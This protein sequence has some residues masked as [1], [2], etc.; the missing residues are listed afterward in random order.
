MKL[1]L[2]WQKVPKLCILVLLGLTALFWYALTCSHFNLKNEK[3]KYGVN[4][5]EDWSMGYVRIKCI[6]HAPELKAAFRVHMLAPQFVYEH[7]IFS[8]M[9]TEHKVK[10]GNKCKSLL[11]VKTKIWILYLSTINYNQLVLEVDNMFP[12]ITNFHHEVV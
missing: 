1:D 4:I 10:Y 6:G 9:W 11:N 12:Q 8:W 7:F 3:H 5:T 2:N